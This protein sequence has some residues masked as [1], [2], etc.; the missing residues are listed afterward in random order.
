VL[1]A[2]QG[3]IHLLC[4]FIAL[5]PALVAED[6]LRTEHR[7]EEFGIGTDLVTLLREFF[8]VFPG[9]LESGDVPGLQAVTLVIRSL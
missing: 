9:L 8:L 4:G 3:L 6:S 1:R 5:L 7:G 2:F